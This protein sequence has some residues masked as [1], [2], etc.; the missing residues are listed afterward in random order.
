MKVGECHLLYISNSLICLQERHFCQ[1]NLQRIVGKRTH[2]YKVV[3]YS[4]S[5]SIDST[6]RDDSVS[7]S[8]NM[9]CILIENQLV[10]TSMH[11]FGNDNLIKC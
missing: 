10:L 5:H 3:L 1:R 8:F 6:S 9:E 7:E 4:C 2:T 11:C